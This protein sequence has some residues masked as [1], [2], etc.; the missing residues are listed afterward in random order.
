MIKINYYLLPMVLSI[1][2]STA[3]AD[4]YYGW[5]YNIQAIIGPFESPEAL[6]ASKGS[7]VDDF[8]STY[9]VTWPSPSFG[10]CSAPSGGL[11]FWR[12]GN[13]CPPG[14]I[15]DNKQMS[16]E[17]P[18]PSPKNEQCENGVKDIDGQ[19]SPYMGCG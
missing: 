6:C 11:N 9:I 16:C 19:C 18:E 4:N 17:L 5:Y 3:M 13:G 10:H 14:T 12:L 8:D 15:Y 2:A 7:K 1:C